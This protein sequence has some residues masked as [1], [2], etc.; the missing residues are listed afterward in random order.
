MTSVAPRLDRIE[1][2]LDQLSETLATLARVEERQYAQTKRMDRFEFRLDT[3]ETQAGAV[4]HSS[5]HHA[6]TLKLAERIVWGVF[7]ASL[8]FLTAYLSQ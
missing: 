2:K 8:S 7:A 1:D 4:S 5:V 6:A 3:V